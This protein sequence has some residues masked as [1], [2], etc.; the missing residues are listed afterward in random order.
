M[1]RKVYILESFYFKG[2]QIPNHELPETMDFNDQLFA[3]F[4]R[5]KLLYLPNDQDSVIQLSL[6]NSSKFLKVTLVRKTGGGR[7][8]GLPWNGPI[9]SLYHPHSG[10]R[11][12]P[13]PKALAPQPSADYPTPPLSSREKFPRGSQEGHFPRKLRKET[14]G[15]RARKT[16]ELPSPGLQEPTRSWHITLPGEPVLAKDPLTWESY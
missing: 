2:A 1:R 6:R 5:K 10:S 12:L 8:P 3:S 14:I 9:S 11:V 16:K 13:F 15:T 4:F 7:R